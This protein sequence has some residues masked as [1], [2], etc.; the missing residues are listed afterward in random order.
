[1]FA[2]RVQ[3]NC[4][5]PGTGAFEVGSAVAGYLTPAQVSGFL[6]ND[7][8]MGYIAWASNT[9]W[10]IGIG[11]LTDATPDTLARTIVRKSTN[12][13]NLVNFTGALIVACCDLAEFHGAHRGEFIT[14]TSGGTASALTASFWPPVFALRNG[15]EVSLK[16]H[17]AIGANATFAPNGLTAKP[18][19]QQSPTAL[20]ATA[21][22]DWPADTIL[23]LRYDAANEVWQIL[24]GMR[25]TP[26][27][28][29]S[30]TVEG[31]AER[32]TMAEGLGGSD[33]TRFITPA[34]LAAATGKKGSNLA[35]GATVTIPSTGGT[36]FVLDGT[37]SLTTV[38]LEGGNTAR[39]AG[40]RVLLG[41]S[42]AKTIVHSANLNLVDNV[43][44]AAAP[45]DLLELVYEGSGVW[46]E[47]DFHVET[48]P[49]VPEPPD[50]ID[51]EVD[52]ANATVTLNGTMQD[53]GLEVSV[54]VPTSTARVVLMAT[55][56]W[57]G[58]D[59]EMRFQW[60]R[61]S[62]DFG[63]DIAQTIRPQGSAHRGI[64]TLMRHDTP[65]AAATYV[66]KLRARKTG[67]G[68][69]QLIGQ[70]GPSGDQA[71]IVAMVI[72]PLA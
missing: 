33:T 23:N 17:T 39:P 41:F 70:T 2:N 27:P 38:A 19:R 24:N 71:Q 3:F 28:S 67:T 21:A 12:S 66:Y 14:Q 55:V 63:P 72:E 20:I 68:T 51:I 54:V 26:V 46:K 13:D 62:T 57:E 53:T 45:G 11:T 50:P 7:R 59:D 18:L 37:T 44:L 6:I 69:A 4:T 30:D 61:D 56:G 64:V 15:L 16:L 5:A 58:D 10:E 49:V 40:F 8:Q 65:G 60:R 47:A 34:I 29:A 36:Y 1:M 31:T 48:T 52:D 43:N 9:E 42:A 32:A 22:G 25:L 35:D